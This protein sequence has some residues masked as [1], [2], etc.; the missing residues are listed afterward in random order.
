M[1]V[2]F[3]SP[4]KP[5]DHP[6]PSGD[7]LMARLLMR[8]LELGG[9]EV[10]LISSL[11]SFRKA[12][13]DE[14]VSELIEAAEDE[15]ERIATEWHAAGPPDLLITYH[16]Y[17]KA[18]DLIGPE[19]AR[20]FAIPYATVEASYSRR[21][22]ESGWGRMQAFVATSL[23]RAA[24]NISM[25]ERDREGILNNFPAAHTALLPPFLDTEPFAALTPKPIAGRL[26]AVAMMRPGDKFDSFAMLSKALALIEDADWHLSVIGDG[27]GRSDVEAL[28]ARFDS[29][30]ISYLGQLDQAEIAKHLSSSS[31]Y[32]WPGCGEA[33]G[34]AYLE[35]QAAGLPVVAQRIAGV[36]SVVID[37]R[38]G[39]L[40]PAGDVGAY[41]EAIRA[42]LADGPRRERLAQGARDF[43][44]D[45]RSLAAASERLMGIIREFTGLTV[46]K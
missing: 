14:V 10:T 40:T 13:S 29:S 15:V 32:V 44:R 33:Y 43:V 5:P 39:I 38:T 16:P 37:G 31:I 21:R 19:L 45:E 46:R 18:P 30:R 35:A 23:E 12:P 3:Y 27:P 1:R 24:V 36:P 8:A 28:F 2:A 7:R 4:I 22:N 34:L 20:R 9:A 25:T 26:A 17:Y 41:A 42:M 6:V 11:R